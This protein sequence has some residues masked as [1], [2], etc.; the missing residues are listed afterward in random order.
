MEIKPGTQTTEFWLAIATN[1]LMIFGAVAGVIPGKYGAALLT[2][3]NVGYAVLRTLVK[4]PDITTLVQRVSHL[5]F[6]PER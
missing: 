6:P 2:V 1:V 4:Q 5:P 3:V